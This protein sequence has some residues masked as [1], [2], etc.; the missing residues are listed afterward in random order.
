M[1][2][3]E[4][5]REWPPEFYELWVERSSIMEFCAHLPRWK[6]EREAERDVRKLAER[7]A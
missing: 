4:K 1:V 6:A 2:L 5:I 3:P 7:S